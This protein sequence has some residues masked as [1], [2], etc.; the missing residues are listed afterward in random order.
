MLGY[1]MCLVMVVLGWFISYWLVLNI[2][3]EVILKDEFNLSATF[4]INQLISHV[5]ALV[6]FIA[7]LVA[8]ALVYRSQGRFKSKRAVLTITEAVF[9]GFIVVM[10]YD[11]S[12]GKVSRFKRIILIDFHLLTNRISL[13]LFSSQS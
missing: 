11:F 1:V 13:L 2:G 5:I 10:A 4:F 7:G 12:R 8:C 9:L 3:Y 6:L